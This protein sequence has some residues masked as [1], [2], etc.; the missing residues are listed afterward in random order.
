LS[1]EFQ[2][3]L[4]RRAR[5]V[6]VALESDLNAQLETYFKLL[7]VWGGKINLTGFDLADP[8]P[9]ALDK[10]LIEPLLAAKH[11]AATAKKMIDIGSGGGS[12][13]IPMLLAAPRL[14]VLLVEAKTRKAV[15]LREALRALGVSGSEVATA[16][17]EELLA[18]PELHEAHDLLTI[19]AVRIESRVL[20]SLQAFVKPSGQLFLFRSGVSASA[21]SFTPP[22]T[23]RAVYPLLDSR[24]SSLSVLEK[25][26]IGA[27]QG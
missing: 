11:V 9:E 6:G 1:R 4:A 10:L 2:E 13:A 15:F 23:A 8:S 12:P 19:R 25:M 22:L 16:R 24:G 17:Y 20:M 5:R 21:G 7:S 3:R 18:R 27:R 26:S 14:K